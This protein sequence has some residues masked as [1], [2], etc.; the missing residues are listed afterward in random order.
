MSQKSQIADSLVELCQ[1]LR[2]VAFAAPSFDNLEI[3]K[4]DTKSWTKLTKKQ[5]KYKV[6]KA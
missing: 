4:F 2:N 5:N 1:E 6:R 3:N